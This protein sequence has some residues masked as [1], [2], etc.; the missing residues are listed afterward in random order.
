M[1]G[2]RTVLFYPYKEVPDVSL[3]EVKNFL[4]LIFSILREKGYEVLDYNDFQEEKVEVDIAIYFHCDVALIKR[5][6]KDRVKSKFTWVLK[7]SPPAP[8]HMTL[9][10]LGYGSYSSVTYKRPDLE[11]IPE[12][13]VKDFLSSTVSKWIDENVCKWG[14]NFFENGVARLKEDD[15]YLIIGQRGD[16]EVVCR[17]DF[18]N[19][20]EKT[21][22]IIEE[23]NELTDRPIVV[24]LHPFTNGEHEDG[25]NRIDLKKKLTEEYTSINPDKV[26]VYSNFSSIH[27]FLLRARCVF[28]GNSGSGYEA[29]MHPKPIISFCYPEYHWAT[30]DLRKICD[31]HNAIKT[32]NWFNP[33][34]SSRFLYWYCKEYCIRDF[35]STRM[36]INNLLQDV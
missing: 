24:K 9:D 20:Y 33:S 16:D 2:K 21:A 10:E 34:L 18:G 5:K 14:D 4:S 3:N 31:I 22:Y 25:F 35:D 23:L 8:N 28:V 19:Y 32:E 7:P 36:R 17:Q 1:S 30:Y 27:E 15:F 29:M 6:V 12:E 13:K 26:K 11:S